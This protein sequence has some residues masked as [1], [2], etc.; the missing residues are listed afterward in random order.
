MKQKIM[1][2]IQ[3]IIMAVLLWVAVTG[4]VYSFK[5]PEKTR[6]QVLLSAPKYLFLDF[7]E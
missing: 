5:H 2:T 1:Y 6:T 7:G 3:I 4:M